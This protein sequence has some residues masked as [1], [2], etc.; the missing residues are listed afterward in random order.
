[1]STTLSISH[2]Q[3]T[4]YRMSFIGNNQYIL[5]EVYTS[6]ILSCSATVTYLRK[7]ELFILLR[8]T[9]IIREPKRFNSII[10]F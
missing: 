7:Y 9:G 4:L 2:P 8:E 1:M 6:S 5:Q 3:E 10:N